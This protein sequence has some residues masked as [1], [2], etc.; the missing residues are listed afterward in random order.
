MAPPQTVSLVIIVLNEEK[1]I[2][3]VIEQ[4][5]KYFDEV[6]VAI[7]SRTTDSTEAVAL[8]CGAK[9]VLLDWCDSFSDARNRAA[10]HAAGDWI[11]MLDADEECSQGLLDSI[12]LMVNQ[13]V[14]DG[15]LLPR[16][17]V[18]TDPP[19]NYPD[20]QLRL[21]RRK[22]KWQRRVHEVI[23][24]SIPQ[25]RIFRSPFDLIHHKLGKTQEQLGKQHEEYQ[26]LLKLEEEDRR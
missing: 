1:N 22:Y 4:H 3:R 8:S 10:D 17:N 23:D 6:L 15:Y 12:H 26:R 16:K 20:L 13:T 25:D 18:Y 19:E 14:I 5:K 11:F 2:Q 7:D 24:R 9:T 21:Y